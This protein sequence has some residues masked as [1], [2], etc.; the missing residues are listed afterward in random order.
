MAIRVET[1]QLDGLS[2]KPDPFA[3]LNDEQR[4]AATFG[5]AVSGLAVS[6]L[7]VSGLP[8][9]GVPG[10]GSNPAANPADSTGPD[11]LLPR[12]RNPP[13]GSTPIEQGEPLPS[14]GEQGNPVEF[15]EENSDRALLV[16]A[17][18]GTGKTTTLAHRVAAQVLS[19]TAPER[20]MLLTFTRRAAIEMTRRTE[21]IVRQVAAERARPLVWAGTF[22]SIANRLLRRFAS[23]LCLAPGF[24]VLDRSD[25]ADLLNYVRGELGLAKKSKRFP[26]KATCLSIYSRALN[27]REPLGDTLTSNYPWASEWE[28]EL[29][30]LFRGYVEAKQKRHLLDYDDLLL[31]WSHLVAEPALA[32]QVR[33]LFDAVLVDEYQDTNAIQSEILFGMC[34]GGKRL[35]VVG[36]DAQ[37]IYSFR[38]ANIE[39]ILG[40]ADNCEPKAAAVTLVEN[41]RSTQLILDAANAVIDQAEHRQ[42]GGF[43]RQLRSASERD[44][45]KPELVTVD[46]EASQV[47]F[48]VEEILAAREAGTMLMDQAVLFRASHH[49]DL[50]EVELGRRNIPFVKFGGLKFLEAAHIKDVLSVLRLAEN[51]L[52]SVAAFRIFQLLPGI[53]PAAAKRATEVL[54]SES[55]A[56]LG[57]WAKL[58]KFKVPS[59]ATEGWMAFCELLE[60][61]TTLSSALGEHGETEKDGIHWASQFE[62]IRSWYAPILEERYESAPAREGDLETLQHVAA[63]YP[64]RERFLSELT[65]DPPAATGDLAGTPHLDE[66]YLIL[67]T[68]HSAKGQEWD[69]VYLLNVVDGAIPSEMA[70]AEKQGLEEERR[71]LYV[72]MTRAKK[73]LHLI[74]PLRYY[75]HNQSRRGDRHVYAPRSRFIGEEIAGLFEERV[76]AG[77]KL[78]GEA[79]D[80]NDS[81]ESAIRVDVAS[82][83]RDMW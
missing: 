42:Q 32:R 61:L 15:C 4:R 59:S 3:Q 73:A 29:R 56:E 6:G 64:S 69:S 49:S 34:P 5:L 10:M 21:R 45:R 83:L 44:G 58:R 25:S 17:G 24:T 79:Q 41:Y 19:G 38:A 77:M 52:D 47:E 39:N 67:S 62:A 57:P 53:G 9:S 48:L 7:P 66:D 16:I 31:Y 23:S 35:T 78:A 37:A 63:A 71:L 33:G 68:I 26:R 50:L 27:A 2:S 81:A 36:D 80:R 22:H 12:L 82:K 72:A 14:Q 43:K 13:R 74:Q 30:N 40:F 1:I 60:R 65:L 54:L 8:V 18:A 70:L 46:D 75:V 55:A 20:I 28:D 76:P 51:P 11:E